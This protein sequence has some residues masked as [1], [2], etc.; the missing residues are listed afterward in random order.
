MRAKLA[1]SEQVLDGI[2]SENFE[3]I[4][5]GA[6]RMKK[7]SENVKWPKSTDAVYQHLGQ[8]FRDQCDRVIERAAAADLQGVHY[9]YLHLTTNCF[10]C[11]NHVRSKFKIQRN[12]DPQGPIQLIPGHWEGETFRPDR[13]ARNG[14]GAN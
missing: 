10:N 8:E 6:R 2:V 5:I 14:K 4:Q 9:A 1:G 11:H 13:T 12:A 3:L 7:I